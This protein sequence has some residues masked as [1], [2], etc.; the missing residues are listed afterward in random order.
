MKFDNHKTIHDTL[1]QRYLIGYLTIFILFCVNI[2]RAHTQSITHDEALTYL[3]IVLQGWKSIFLFFDSNNHTLHS[4]LVK[5][6]TSIFGLS[7]L[8][9]RIPALLG[10]LL[11][12][13]SA[14]RLCRAFCKGRFEY[15][16]SL[17]ALT[18]SPFILD[19]LV[20]ARGYSLALGF[21]MLAV[22]LCALELRMVDAQEKRKQ[23]I[24][25]YVKISCLCALSVA[26]NLSFAFVNASLL[27]I[28]FTWSL[29]E[30]GL[31]TSNK[32][33]LK[34]MG[35]ELVLLIAPGTI[36]YLVLNPAIFSFRSATM[37]YGHK[38]WSLVYNSVIDATFDNDGDK[39]LWMKQSEFILWIVDKL[40]LLLVLCI[41]LGGIFALRSLM[42]SYTEKSAVDGNLKLWLFI[43]AI[44]SATIAMHSFAYMLFGVL[45]PA[46]RTGI[47][48]VPLSILLACIFLGSYRGG[49][50]QLTFGYVGR[51]SLLL[52]VLYF[53]SSFHI[54]YF[55]Q[56]K[57]DAGSKDVYSVLRSSSRE[58][59]NGIGINWV[60][61]PSLN[62]YRV[63]F[64]DFSIPP[65]T[66]KKP[67]PNQ[68]YFVL[69]P[70]FSDEDRQFIREHN[71]EVI[72]QHPVSKAI[73][74]MK[75]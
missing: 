3:Y 24:W 56:W 20:A 74:G 29:F 58:S 17:A 15:I 62:F 67:D 14:E 70:D 8:S 35:H 32:F 44:V 9:M 68:T 65:F 51:I 42:R 13:L 1:K 63:L 12:L 59:G 49:R 41:L 6:S 30:Q 64:T 2:I 61:E 36:V 48:F 47:F 69:L 43:F 38:T 31:F 5:L 34:S 46:E 28:F 57:Y 50:L 73:V 19:Y 25:T 26:S 54:D 45:L 16:L 52:I 23:H 37:Y 7:H 66:R 18:T 22:L 72:F 53:L 33:A 4:I 40:P 27:M 10:G 60:L 55:R 75:K 71:I 39:Y 21:F 11:Y